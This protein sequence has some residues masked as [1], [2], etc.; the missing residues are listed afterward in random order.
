MQTLL[1]S[2]VHVEFSCLSATCAAKTGCTIAKRTVRLFFGALNV[3]YAFFSSQTMRTFP[4][5]AK[6]RK[7]LLLQVRGVF[8]V[9]PSRAFCLRTLFSFPSKGKKKKQEE[10]AD[11]DDD[12]DDEE[13]GSEEE[14]KKNER[15][16]K[17]QRLEEVCLLC[18]LLC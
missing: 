12:D 14:P 7:N 4:R 9:F 10:C 17:Q 1:K 18:S 11:D 5:S 13:S 16:S 15:K 3:S 6:A 2:V 8:V